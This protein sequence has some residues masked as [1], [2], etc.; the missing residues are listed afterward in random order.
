MYLPPPP[1]RPPRPHGKAFPLQLRVPKRQT[2]PSLRL[3]FAPSISDMNRTVR[4]VLTAH[5]VIYLHSFTYCNP[6]PNLFTFYKYF[7][8]F[9]SVVG[10][11]LSV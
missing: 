7:L 2:N 9:M 1:S 5:T 8:A 3:F 10:F 4:T 11:R 6:E